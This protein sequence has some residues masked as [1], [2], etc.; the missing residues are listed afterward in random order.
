MA[1]HSLQRFLSDLAWCLR[2]GISLALLFSCL[3]YL[4]SFNLGIDLISHFR[5]QY[6][7]IGAFGAIWFIA[8]RQ[9]RWSVPG[10]LCCALNIYAFLPL[11]GGGTKP[12]LGATKTLLMLNVYTANPEKD[13][14]VSAIEALHPDVIVGVEV[15]EKWR[16]ALGKLSTLPHQIF[17]PRDDNFGIG[18]LSNEP[19]QHAEC[20]VWVTGLPPMCRAELQWLGTQFALLGIHTVPP[21]S[22]NGFAS[23][24]Q[25]L[26]LVRESLAKETLPMVV[27]GDL[28]TSMWSPGYRRFMAGS[29]LKQSRNGFGVI[30]TWPSVF[31]LLRV[32]IDH[33]LFSD[34][35]QIVDISR[36]TVPGS[37]HFGILVKVALR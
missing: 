11:Y 15:D 3:P 10:L 2:A 16:A 24:E 17:L 13:A 18:I 30:P 23:R 22:P 27:A 6:T 21:R 34:E 9:Y 29:R 19:L 1:R 8:Q 20:R 4:D 36:V 14:V 7:F 25:Q 5:L 33:A 28:N 37:D 35:F 12:A 31:P 26:Q 32:P